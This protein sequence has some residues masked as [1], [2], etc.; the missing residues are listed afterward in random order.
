MHNNFNIHKHS[1]QISNSSYSLKQHQKNSKNHS[2][3]EIFYHCSFFLHVLVFHTLLL[4]FCIFF[5]VL[6]IGMIFLKHKPSSLLDFLQQDF[7]LKQIYIFLGDDMNFCFYFIQMN[8]SYNSFQIFYNILDQNYSIYCGINFFHMNI[9][10]YSYSKT[11]VIFIYKIWVFY[12][13]IFFLSNEIFQSIKIFYFLMN[14]IF[15]FLDM[16]FF[17][18]FQLES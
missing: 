5:L 12:Y 13:K 9:Q 4:I 16:I 7:A 18:Y 11:Y 14:K 17:F 10:D 15:F 8:S 6:K 2:F 3:C 1:L